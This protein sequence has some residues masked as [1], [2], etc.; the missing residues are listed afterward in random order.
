MGAPE[1]LSLERSYNSS[2]WFANFLI[3]R[4]LLGLGM[5]AGMGATTARGDHPLETA[6]SQTSWAHGGS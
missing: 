5:A 4:E 3:V 2:L 6:L 1:L